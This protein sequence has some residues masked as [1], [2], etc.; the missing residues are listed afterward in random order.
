MHIRLS[1]ALVLAVGL[2]GVDRTAGV[3]LRRTGGPARALALGRVRR[4][5]VR[6]LA[7]LFDRNTQHFL[8]HFPTIL[9]AYRSRAMAYGCFVAELPD[10][11]SALGDSGLH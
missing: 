11:E 1:V 3:A 4:S 9:N 5:G 10:T 8:D 2:A 6:W 7:K